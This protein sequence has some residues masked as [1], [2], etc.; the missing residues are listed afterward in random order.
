[1]DVRPDKVTILVDAAEF[2]NEIDVDRA[3]AA[4]KRAKE[5][6]QNKGQDDIN[7]DRAEIALKKAMNRLRVSKGKNFE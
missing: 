5:R 6:L 3:L 7:A 2:A 1:M 4:K